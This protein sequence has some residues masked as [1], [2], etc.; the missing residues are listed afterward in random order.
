MSDNDIDKEFRSIVDSFIALANKHSDTANRE[1]VSMALLY[2]AARFNS[3]IV[4]TH[5]PDP[6][7]YQ[8]DRAAAGP[9]HGAPSGR[10]V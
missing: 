8:S 2:A 7:K 6:T 9:F 4:A 5:A 1:N 10:G 3:F